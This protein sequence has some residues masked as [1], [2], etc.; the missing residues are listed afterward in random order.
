LYFIFEEYGC[1]DSYEREIEG[2]REKENHFLVKNI[3]QYQ[4]VKTITGVINV[5]KLSQLLIQGIYVR[6]LLTGCL[7]IHIKG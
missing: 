1:Y 7:S 4:I 2:R 6:K 3:I 5:V